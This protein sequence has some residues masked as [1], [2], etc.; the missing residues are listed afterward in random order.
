MIMFHVMLSLQYTYF[1][2]PRLM[3]HLLGIKAALWG[4]ILV[5]TNCNERATQTLDW[6]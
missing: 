6:A 5:V 4:G 1:T 3:H 2:L